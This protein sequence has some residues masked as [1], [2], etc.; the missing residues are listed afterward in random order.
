VEKVPI[1]RLL[2]SDEQWKRF[3]GTLAD[4]LKSVNGKDRRMKLLLALGK[5][6]ETERNLFQPAANPQTRGS[7]GS[8]HA[9]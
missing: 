1:N 8:F 4:N 3:C 5:I 7:R 2:N 6:G 9:H